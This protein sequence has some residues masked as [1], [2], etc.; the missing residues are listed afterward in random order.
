MTHKR[1]IKR[2]K[3]TFTMPKLS[4]PHWVVLRLIFDNIENQTTDWYK[5][6]RMLKDIYGSKTISNATL[7]LLAEKYG[8]EYL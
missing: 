3:E 6:L 4:E 2:R 8:P 1:S 7:L 5:A